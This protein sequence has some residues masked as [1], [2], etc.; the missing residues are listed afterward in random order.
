MLKELEGKRKT[1]IKSVGK[2]HIESKQVYILHKSKLLFINSNVRCLQI[3]T[4]Q[5]VDFGHV[6]QHCHGKRKRKSRGS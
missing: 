1:Y 5:Y 2:L 6:R 3:L 4:T